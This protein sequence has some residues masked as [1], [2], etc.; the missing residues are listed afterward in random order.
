MLKTTHAG[1]AYEPNDHAE[2]A[3]EQTVADAVA[4]YERAHREY[5]AALKHKAPPEEREALREAIDLARERLEAACEAHPHYSN[6]DY[7]AA[8]E[9]GAAWRGA[10][11]ATRLPF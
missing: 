7:A 1:T 2:P 9:E 10:M 11:Q 4:A 5:R 6:P 8:I 3:V